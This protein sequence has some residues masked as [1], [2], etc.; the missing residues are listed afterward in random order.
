M[1]QQ[2]DGNSMAG[3]EQAG[4]ET[5][6][7]LIAQLTTPSAAVAQAAEALDGPV[8]ILGAGGKMGP[9]LA[10]LLARAGAEVIAVSRFSRPGLR[11][12]LGGAG[13]GTVAADLMEEGALRSLPDA[14]QVLLL[15]GH[16][17][18]SSGN[19]AATWAVNAELPGRLVA[20]YRGAR[21][22]YV[23][24]GNVYPFS[25]AA[26]GGSR[27]TDP[28][29]PVGE[30]AQS[31][32]GGERL[33]EYAALKHGTA[34]LTVRLFYAAEL[35]YGI[36]RDIAGRVHAGEPVDLTTGHVNQIWQGDANAWLARSFPLCSTP[37]EVL[38]MT[39]PEVLSVRDIAAAAGAEMGRRPVFAGSEAQTSLLGNAARLIERLGPP[40]IAVETM[41]RWT[42][43]WV[44]MGGRSLGMPT[45]YE[46]RSGR[47]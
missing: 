4:I 33:A 5:E 40:Q 21:V 41:I 16:K 6:E 24:S 13:V 20:R 2:S 8:V 1:A 39:G 19:P 22:I 27:E 35:R 47:F 31:R 25:A 15:A 14:G 37:P 29:G 34:L 26:S 36:I 3:I 30:Y 38:N 44:V 12:Y 7:Q 10:E 18:G 9:T 45:H 11:E 17:F 28:V 32:L 23:S 42:A 46:V 43:R